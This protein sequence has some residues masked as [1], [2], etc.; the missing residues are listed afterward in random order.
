MNDRPAFLRA[1]LENPDDDAPRLV[2]A[3]WLD[4]RQ[5]PRGQFIRVQ[6]ALARIE[7]EVPGYCSDRSGKCGTC[8]RIDALRGDERRLLGSHFEKWI[9]GA[10]F[11]AIGGF[12]APYPPTVDFSGPPHDYSATFRRGFVERVSVVWEDCRD[13]LDALLAAAPIREV[14]LTTWPE[15]RSEY[16]ERSR[17]YRFFLDG[18]RAEWF[19]SEETMRNADPSVFDVDPHSGYSRTIL[20]TLLAKC[21]SAV[22]TWNL[23]PPVPRPIETD[24]RHDERITVELLDTETGERRTSENQF[25]A[26]WWAEGNGSCDCNRAGYF[27]VEHEAGICAGATR[28]LIVRA[29]TTV[30]NLDELN[31]A[32]SEELR[33]RHLTM[34]PRSLVELRATGGLFS[35]MGRVIREAERGNAEALRALQEIAASPPGP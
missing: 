5:D 22:K 11:W 35:R 21:W 31:H 26:F 30:Y 13:H 14:T 34:P 12:G 2:F 18:L 1:I 6:C 25:S 4:E 15:I 7:C 29:S 16:H 24:P 8:Y 33:R 23:P 3:D 19:V 28:F 32:Y 10:L 27:D 17:Y 9:P 20:R